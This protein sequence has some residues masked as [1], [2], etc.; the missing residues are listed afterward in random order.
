MGS[1]E[2]NKIIYQQGEVTAAD[3]KEKVDDKKAG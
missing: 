1:I 2:Q 3:L